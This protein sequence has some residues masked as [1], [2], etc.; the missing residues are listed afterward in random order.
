MIRALKTY[1][2]EKY[3]IDSTGQI[4]YLEMDGL[5]CH[6]HNGWKTIWCYYK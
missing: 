1:K 5:T 3:K 2:D 6:K 4:L